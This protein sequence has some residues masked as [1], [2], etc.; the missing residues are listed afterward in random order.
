VSDKTEAYVEDGVP[1]MRIPRGTS[2]HRVYSAMCAYRWAESMSP[3]AWEVVRFVEDFPNVT[4]WQALH[5]A[6]AVHVSGI[7][8]NWCNVG[9]TDMKYGYVYMNSGQSYNMAISLA[10]PL[11]WHKTED[12]LKA[13]TGRTCDAVQKVADSIGPAVLTGKARM[14]VPALLIDGHAKSCDV[15]NEKWTPL[16][17]FAVTAGVGQWDAKQ[18]REQLQAM[19]NDVLKDHNALAEL[20]DKLENPKQN[21]NTWQYDF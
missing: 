3:F 11:F 16:Y 21:Q 18:V 15:L 6:M 9:I 19:Y 12:E 8:H 7:G 2:H 17:Q 20:R 4:I 13:I 14:K 5:Y 10:F 1:K